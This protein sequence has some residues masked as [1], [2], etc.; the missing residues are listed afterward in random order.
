MSKR[1]KNVA[2]Q[3]LSLRAQRGNP[4]N[5]KAFMLGSIWIAASLPATLR[6]RLKAYSRND[7]PFWFRLVRLRE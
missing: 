4:A 2:L 5:Q 7:C 3:R 6:S 1:D